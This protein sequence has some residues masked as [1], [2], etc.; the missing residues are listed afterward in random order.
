MFQIGTG[1]GLVSQIGTGTGLVYQIGTGTGLVYQIGTGGRGWC[2]NLT[3]VKLEH[4]PRP[5]VP[6]WYTNPVPLS[7]GLLYVDDLFGLLAFFV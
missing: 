6:I 2:S 1:T 3:K 5:P 7:H 4:Q